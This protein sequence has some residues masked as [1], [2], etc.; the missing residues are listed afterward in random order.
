VGEREHLYAYVSAEMAGLAGVARWKRSQKKDSD[1][2]AAYA[3]ASKVNSA[4]HSHRRRGF[5]FCV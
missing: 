3:I 1:G 5:I 4:N 2:L